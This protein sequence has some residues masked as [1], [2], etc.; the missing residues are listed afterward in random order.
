MNS[1][2]SFELQVVRQL[3][4]L[5]SVP[6]RDA[7]RAQVGRAAFLQEAR[8]LAQTVSAPAKLRPIGLKQKILSLFSIRK[9]RSPM[10]RDRKSVV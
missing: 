10:L 5:R 7:Q 9:E 6:Q 4:K 8:E 3:E 1:I 2:E